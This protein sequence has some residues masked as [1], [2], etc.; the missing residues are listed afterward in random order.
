[1][2]DDCTQRRAQ[3]H[4]GDRRNPSRQSRVVTVRERRVRADARDSQCQ[5]RCRQI[6]DCEFPDSSIPCAHRKRCQSNQSKRLKRMFEQTGSVSDAARRRSQQKGD[7]QEKR[8]CCKSN[9]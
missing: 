4:C 2:Y 9:L 8:L 7:F 3:K 1:M 5:D 6:R